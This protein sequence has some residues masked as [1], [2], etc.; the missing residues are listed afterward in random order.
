MNSDTPK[1][2]TH[3]V[4]SVAVVVL[5]A[6]LFAPHTNHA[7]Q[8]QRG[9]SV[10][11]A[12]T[13]NAVPMPDADDANAW[14]VA[15]T[16]D[17]SLYLGKD[18]ITPPDNLYYDM[19]SRLDK[20]TKSRPRNPTEKLFIKADARVPVAFLYRVLA[21]ARALDFDAPVLLTSQP[22]SAAP[23][24]I[25]P[26]RGLEVRIATASSARS[27][28]VEVLSSE[29]PSPKVKINEEDIPWNKCQDTLKRLVEV[30]AENLIV[31][32][33]G[34]AVPFAQLAPVIDVC[35]STG[36]TVFLEM[37]RVQ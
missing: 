24:A 14:I 26:P 31:I 12:V 33:S 34:G 28:V 2:S 8:L 27:I 3:S 32:K 19:K 6:A 1:Q 36:A 5:A 30:Q 20:E 18:P 13:S 21:A 10:Q 23:G 17:G 25:L 7:Q 22:E 16:A 15:I 11:L 9:V 35:H 37:P 4:L 29:Q